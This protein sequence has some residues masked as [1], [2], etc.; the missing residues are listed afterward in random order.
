MIS[1]Q[2]DSKLICIESKAFAHCIQLKCIC[3][4]RRVERLG[5]ECFAHC[6]GLESL[7]FE[8]GSRLAQIGEIPFCGCGRLRC[9]KFQTMD[10]SWVLMQFQQQT[11]ISKIFA[12]NRRIISDSEAVILR[13]DPRQISAVISPSATDLSD[14]DFLLGYDQCMSLAFMMSSTP[15]KPK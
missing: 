3:I 10:E 2:S 12:W 9:I 13:E 7:M 8:F 1:F 5:P 6:F 14:E 15:S 11:E 4:P